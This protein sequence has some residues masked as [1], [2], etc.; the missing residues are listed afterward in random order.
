MQIDLKNDSN[1]WTNLQKLT[2]C[3]TLPFRDQPVIL[4]RL[5]NGPP[6]N[7]DGTSLT[8]ADIEAGDV[9]GGYDEFY[10]SE[11]EEGKENLYRLTQY[12]RDNNLVRS[13]DNSGHIELMP[14]WEARHHPTVSREVLW[15][16]SRFPALQEFHWYPGE[17]V[18][19]VLWK[20]TI[21]RTADQEVDSVDGCLM[22]VGSCKGSPPEI[23]ILVEQELAYYMDRCDANQYR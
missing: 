16:A 3:A 21:T 19:E 7:K 2:I 23:P 18:Q 8:L 20:W 15:L 4:P 11:E 22:W 14:M 13:H 9:E 6:L 10:D 5:N 1:T 12:L 17:P